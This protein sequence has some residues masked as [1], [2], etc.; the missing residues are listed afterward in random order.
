M[1][2]HNEKGMYSFNIDSF[3]Q[4]YLK[5]PKLFKNREALEPSFI[6]DELPHRNSEI[7]KI[8]GITACALKGD[9]PPN[10]LCYGMTGT[11]KTATVRY[12]SQK[13]A[14]HCSNKPP[15]WVYINCTVVSTPYRILAHIYNTIVGKEKIPSTGLPKDVILKKLLGLFDQHI[16][17]SIC[18]LVLDEIDILIEK[19][20]GNEILYNLTRLN[21]NLDQCRTSVIGISNKLK[22]MEFLDARVTSNL[23]E[24]EPIVFH[25]YDANQ[26]Y[27]ILKLRAEVA[28]KEGVI[29]DGV[30]KLCAGL[31]AKEH[32][33]AR[34]ALQLLRKAGEIAER[35]QTKKIMEN[36]VEKAQKDIDK[37]HIVEY[38]F[39]MPLQVKLTLIAVFLLSK[40]TKEHIIITSGDIYEV[41]SE[42]AQIIPNVKQLTHRRISDYINELALSGLITAETKSMGHYGRTKIVKLDIEFKL[43]ER[44]LSQVKKIKEYR[45]MDYKPII[46]QTDKVKIKNM[47]F[48]KLI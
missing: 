43:I 28:F 4:N 1:T 25:P 17:D 40:H 30:I 36:H 29:D 44:V 41:H 21:E 22:F 26:L 13:L 32:G 24:E 34:K 8:A 3:Y 2:N 6:P 14:Q 7:E 11:G 38:I 15:W 19:K 23:G 27:D 20:G 10:F 47:V 33:D 42:L 35:N 18:F 12:I 37:D 45:L 16:K 31:A 5:G 48:K 9:V 46:L 39:S